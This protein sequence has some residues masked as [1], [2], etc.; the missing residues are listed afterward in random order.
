MSGLPSHIFVVRHGSRLDAAD[1]QWHLSSPTPYDPPL[2]YGGWLQARQVGAQIRNYL[3]QAK[4]D[5]APR[6]APSKPPSTPP[7]EL[8]KKRFRVVIH[9][10]P[11]LRCVQTSVGIS[12]GLAQLVPD[13]PFAPADLIVPAPR[14]PGRPETSFRSSIL[15]LDSYLGEWLS[16]NYFENI[17]PPPSSSLMLGTAKADLLRREDY[18]SYT[19]SSSSAVQTQAR[20]GSLWNSSSAVDLDASPSD[21]PAQ[22]DDKK[23]R[24]YF[25][26]RPTFSVSTGGKIPEGFVAHARDHCVSVDYQWDS[27][28]GPLHCGDGG[29]LGEEWTSMHYRFRRGVTKMLNWYATTDSP[30]QMVTSPA[31]RAKLGNQGR[32]NDEEGEVVETVVV[33]VSHGAGCN[34]L[35]GAI[36]HQPVL[37][38]VGIASITMA[39]R[40]PNLDYTQLLSDAQAREEKRYPGKGGSALVPVHELYDI[41][42]SASTEHLRNNSSTPVSSPSFSNNVWN[43]AP[44]PRTSTIGSPGTPLNLGGPSLSAFVYSDSPGNRSSPTTSTFTSGAPTR[45]DPPLPRKVSRPSVLTFGGGPS[46][47][48]SSEYLAG[49]PSPTLTSPATGLWSP[50]PSS[51]RFMDDAIDNNDGGDD[52]DSFP[53]F[54]HKRFKSPTLSQTPRGDAAEAP[55]SFTKSTSGPVLAGPIKLQTNWDNG[56]VPEEVTVPKTEAGLWGQPT[57]SLE[58][59]DPMVHDGGHIKRRWTVTDTPR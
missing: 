15:R 8:R 59:L 3:E 20:K 46:P 18:S 30:E 32:D 5:E 13:S 31:S 35:I 53:D 21:Y 40:K 57:R 44:R 7:P 14:L 19:D 6:A 50:A 2:T 17:T 51:L 1:N 52:D 9:S 54:D 26:P 47:A 27:M 22:T 55:Y 48:T 56:R 12:A 4:L 33:I 58:E 25:P 38:D 24:G 49:G 45:R 43:N 10:S 42:L 23:N 39:V 29:T 28:R 11:F 36:T 41:R 34:A 16:P 37:M